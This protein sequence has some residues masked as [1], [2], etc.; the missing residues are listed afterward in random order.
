MKPAAM[1]LAASSIAALSPTPLRPAAQDAS[2]PEE[3]AI[4]VGAG[5]ASLVREV[6]SAQLV[7][8][9]NRLRVFDV[10]PQIRPETAMLRALTASDALDLLEQS[11]WFEVL[12]VERVLERLAGRP[13]DLLRFHESGVEEL[14]GR[15]LF[16]PRVP[17]PNGDVPLPLYLEQDDGRIRLLDG[18]EIEIDALPPGD[19]N[20]LRLDWRVACRRPD[21]YRFELLY[22]SSGLH[23][24]ADH[25]LRIAADGATC[26]FSS[27]ATVENRTGKAWSGVRL[28]LAEDPPEEG[29]PVPWHLRPDPARRAD[30]RLHAVAENAALEPHSTVQHALAQ[31]RDAPLSTTPSVRISRAEGQERTAVVRRYE[32]QDPDARGIGR[33][34]P[35][36]A[37]QV[38]RVDRQNRPQ[39]LAV[40]RNE[41]V[42]D[43][44]APWFL[45][46]PVE[47]LVAA[48]SLAAGAPGAT[49]VN[50]MLRSSRPDPVQVDVLCPIDLDET[51][52]GASTSPDRFRPQIARFVVGVAGHGRAE[53][54]FQITRR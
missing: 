42:A 33:A 13:V 48:I 3:V 12:D 18:A 14:R 32:L 7:A 30:A 20:R 16:P 29:A 8:G 17:G 53:L 36:G 38:V 25:R 45:G 52:T 21:R 49:N 44:E 23:W 22:V 54:T 2:A 27:V 39:L 9:E 35:A 34:L 37:A 19:W 51:I 15:L 24:R 50:V 11:A 46:E 4:T 10:S 41:A 31:V 26:D 1:L 28:S 5:G 40:G 47:G 43:G 6:R